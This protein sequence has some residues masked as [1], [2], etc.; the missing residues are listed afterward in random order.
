MEILK[1]DSAAASD[2]AGPRP[3]A[4]AQ[5]TVAELDIEIASHEP[6]LGCFNPRCLLLDTLLLLMFHLTDTSHH[7]ST[8]LEALRMV[9]DCYHQLFIKSTPTRHKNKGITTQSSQPGAHTSIHQKQKTFFPSQRPTPYR[10]P[11]VIPPNILPNRP[12]YLRLQVSEDISK[13]ILV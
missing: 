1:V 8:N 7:L 13:G 2:V 11:F 6:M 4:S 10:A 5:A 12:R 9:H 3:R